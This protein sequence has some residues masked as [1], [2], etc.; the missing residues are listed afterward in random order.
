MSINPEQQEIEEKQQEIQDLTDQL[1]DIELLFA[2]EYLAIR[3]FSILL[4]QEVTPL[5]TRLDRWEERM[6]N[7]NKQLDQLRDIRD[8]H[9]SVSLEILSSH[10]AVSST[11]IIPHLENPSSPTEELFRIYQALIKRFH[12]DIESDNEKRQ[13]RIAIMS[14]V[15][16][17]FV[18]QDIKTLSSYEKEEDIPF[19][20][21]DSD[22]LVRLVRRIARLRSLCKTAEE[23]T[24]EQSESPLGQLLQA[25]E[26]ASTTEKFS[27]IKETLE[28][29]IDQKKFSWLNQ[30][31]RSAQLLTEVDP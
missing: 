8:Q 3:H 1:I 18:Q 17:A 2:K 10:R 27:E 21:L 12:P 15:N 25:T 6:K 23:R 28:E 5:Y 14:K 19:T 9:Q 31:M 22:N 13:A 7:S 30:Q 4:T 24:K 26:G 20:Q 11:K 29:L 16:Q